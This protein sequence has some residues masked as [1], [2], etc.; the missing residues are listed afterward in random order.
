MVA[1]ALFAGLLTVAK[2]E[3]MAPF[4]I[5]AGSAARSLKQFA[6]Q[7]RLSIVYDARSVE[8]VRTNDVDGLLTPVEALRRLLEGT[9]LH[10]NQ[11]QETGA[12]AVNRAAVPPE[13]ARHGPIETKSSPMKTLST[14]TA[15]EAK[16]PHQP[17][18][19]FTVVRATL[20]ALLTASSGFAQT[21]A[22]KPTEEIIE[23]SPF[24]VSSSKDTGYYAAQTLAGGRIVTDIKNT[25]TSIEVLTK[26]L[27]DDIGANTVEDFLQ[28]TT[29]GQVGGSQGNFTGASTGG[30]F[31]VADSTKARRSPSENTRLRGIGSPDYVR[32]Y[33]KTSIPLDGYNTTRVDINRG[34]NSFLFGLGSPAGLINANY[35]P[36][37]MSN[38]TEFESQIGTGG[39]T[40]STRESFNFNRMLIKDKL[41]VRGAI[42]HDRT[43]YRQQPSYRSDDRLYGAITFKPFKNTSI[44]VHAEKGRI[45]GN[46]PDTLLPSE[47]ISTFIQQRTP[48]DIFYNIQH[49][50]NPEGPQY[51]DWIKMSA[52]DQ[53]R[54]IYQ[55]GP[56]GQA[57][58]GNQLLKDADAW[59]YAMVY[60][61]RNG[62]GP[63]FAFQPYLSQN[64]YEKNGINPGDPFWDPAVLSDGTPGGRADGSPAM[65]WWRNN[66]YSKEIGGIGPAQG[67]TNLDGFDFSKQNFGGDSDFYINEFRTY[68]ATFEQLFLNG[69]IGFEAGFD[70]EHVEKDAL[71]NFN[72]WK[73]EFLIDINQTLPLPALNANGAFKK[74]SSGN[75][76]SEAMINPNYGRP[77]YMTE[78]DRSVSFEDRETARV[79]AFA[80]YD[81]GKKH[82]DNSFLKWLGNHTLTFLG[83]NF[84]EKN[85]TANTRQQTFSDSFN[86]PWQIGNPQGDL[87]ASGYRRLTKMVYMGPAI[88]S[89]INDPFNPATPIQLSDIK[90]YSSTADLKAE[91]V[92]APL[93]YWNLGPDAEGST[94]INNTTIN[95]ANNYRGV[96]GTNLFVDEP[97]AYTGDRREFWDRATLEGRSELIENS[98]RVTKVKSKALNLQSMFFGDH[99][100]ANVG[101]RE[102]KVKNWLNSVPPEKH[103]LALAGDL[104][105]SYLGDR[106]YLVDPEYFLPEKG[107]FSEFD[108]GPTGQGSFG[109]GGVLHIPQNLLIV[110][111]PDWLGLSLHYNSSKNFVPDA[112]RN[113]FKTGSPGIFGPLASPIG[114]GRDVGFTVNLN[115]NKFVARFNWFESSIQ[116]NSAGLGNTLNGLAFWAIRGRG[117]A[118]EDIADLDPDG[119]HII[120]KRA[121]GSPHPRAGDARWD[122]NRVYEVL[123]ATQFAVDDGWID[124]K[125]ANGL[126]SFNPSGSEKR[127]EWFPGLE[128]TS[129]LVAK[130]FELNLTYN[131]TNS[132]RI[133]FNASKTQS[134]SS[135]VG[136][137][138]SALMNKF[139][140][141]YNTIKGYTLWDAADTNSNN[142]FSNWFQ[143]MVLTYYQKK[144]QEGSANNEVREWSGNVV[145]NYSF[146]Q[147]R[148]KGFSV[149][150]AVRF[151]SSGAIGYPLMDYAVSPGVVM[152]VPDVKNPWMGKDTWNVDLNAGYTRRIMNK[153]VSWT[154]RLHLKNVN[155]FKSDKVS[156]VGANFNGTAATV[157]WDPPLSILLTNTFGF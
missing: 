45:K 47:A 78:P 98:T 151:Q 41:A 62:T 142:P 60:D 50:G 90:I 80:K 110:K 146:Q 115:N 136:P 3:T 66:R 9:P 99:L 111:L 113:T 118:V 128:D 82:A 49:F 153:R 37:S 52:A 121:D 114:K 124:G 92:K 157:R 64:K 134:I 145:T 71:T 67:Y 86:L 77:V 140:D 5:P 116:N 27:L 152:K 84:T 102:D 74:D 56:D 30:E 103:I 20:A 18:T 76:V 125:I 89:Y 26:Q 123:K 132:W 11:D 148:L 79:T 93:T 31:G 143:P 69:Q 53:A 10:F 46:A 61:G 117:W 55:N 22:T 15:V 57:R 126:L 75:V 21:A 137:A 40:P 127:Q 96:D 81:F 7:A 73:G 65:M 122:V 39:D 24:I 107:I 83:D 129:D 101:Y 29:G 33:Y 138:T 8:D 36:A 112:S 59:G 48:V 154:C 95:V 43:T 104:P 109:Y 156:T 19:V 34:A 141:S 97:V 54:F 94:W 35:A 42:L 87:P 150:G 88:Q 105:A 108:K 38:T 120:D 4:D 100:V 23:L 14:P 16:P 149:G 135:N 144:L 1:L 13:F 147:G 70:K 91:N 17:N 63:S 28:Y 68:N 72:G 44:R 130:G 51:A 2:T 106:G 6:Q 131:P 155:N 139:F 58:G 133:S 119:N 25:G 85:R 32:D 12:I